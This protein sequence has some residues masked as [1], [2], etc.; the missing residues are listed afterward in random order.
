VL[1]VD[2]NANHVE[3]TAA[4][5]E[6]TNEDFTVVTETSAR[7]GLER[8]E[9]E[10]IDCI[11]SDYEMP[12]MDGLEFLKAVREADDELPFILFTGRGSEEV[13]SDAIAAGVTDYLQKDT[14]TDQYE[15]LAN[16]IHNYVTKTRTQKALIHTEEEFRHL[17]DAVTNY[18]IFMLD[19]EGYVTSWNRGAE[20]IKG[21]RK[22]EIVGEHISTFYPDDYEEGYPSRLLEQASAD[23]Y[24]EDEGWRLR[25][26]GSRFWANV[27]ITAL[28]GDD[29][30]VRGYAKVTRDMTERKRQREALQEEKERFQSMV[31][32]V[33]D[34]GIFMLDSDGHVTSWNA[35]AEQIK[36]YQPE[37]ILGDHFSVFYT[38]EDTER[39]VPGQLLEQAR[40]DGRVE[41]EGWRVRKDGSRFWA[42]VVITALHDN[43]GDIRGFSK[44]TRDM[45][46][47]REY[48]QQLDH[49]TEQIEE[50]LRVVAHDLQSPVSVAKGNFELARETGE[51]VHFETVETALDRIS[52][53]IEEI[54]DISETGVIIRDP[55]RV[56]LD[57]VAERAWEMVET[58]PATLVT[59]DL[60][61]VEA[62]DAQLQS[63][64]ENLF[65]NA[66]TYG[67]DVT[68]RVGA[69]EN[70]FYVA[71]DGP[72]ITAADREAVLE[73]GY[74]TRDSGSGFGL[75]IVKTVAEAH[76]WS[77]TV[78]ESADGGARFE[79]DGV[80]TVE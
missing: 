34:Y 13:A 28:H 59:D 24:I 39:G 53:I 78:T 55:S 44:V 49:Q 74:S 70:G 69:L 40:A 68:V 45:T 56:A 42:D 57:D 30:T 35:G 41:N 46:D 43:D 32:E 3:M 8:L 19:P 65:Q 58:G 2:D 17:V 6:Q 9:T 4:F 67:G 15:V 12:R 1:H 22:E 60:E 33:K 77:L 71:D 38:D 66:V 16:R 26:D 7:D 73:Y 37:E 54:L 75:S 51:A 27:T 10:R 11:V 52:T 25:K 23:N 64:F 62:D 63:I 76:G 36:G 20:A 48:Q 61:D 80:P 5:L 14:G 47:R 79:I 31:Q 18:A 21:Y 50:L 72:G 29:G